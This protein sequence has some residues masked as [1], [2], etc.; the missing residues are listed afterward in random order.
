MDLATAPVRVGLAVAEPGFRW[1]TAR[2]AWRSAPSA[3]RNGDRNGSASFAHMLGLDDAVER[4]N[5]LARLMDDDA[6]LGRALAPNG[7]IDRLLQPGGV[8][9]Q[10]TAEGGVLDRLTA[11]NGAS[12]GRSRLAGSS[13]R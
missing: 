10:L 2:S 1:P 4:A 8:V 6:P 3:K 5:R 9:D 7:P 11:E 13:T 12:P